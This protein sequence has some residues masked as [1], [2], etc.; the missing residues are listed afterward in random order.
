MLDR[1][2]GKYVFECD[3]CKAVLETETGDFDD[4]QATRKREQWKAEKVG[5]VWIHAC[6]DCEVD[7]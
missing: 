5:D 1:Q 2:H 7:R 4:A 6:P 3:S